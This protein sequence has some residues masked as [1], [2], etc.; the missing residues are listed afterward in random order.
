MPMRKTIFIHIGTHKTGSTSIQYFLQENAER[1]KHCGVYVARSGIDVARRRQGNHNVAWDVRRDIRYERKLGGVA[2]LLDE[3][4]DSPEKTVVISSED[5]E[6]LVRY[7]EELKEF[8]RKL[9]AIGYDRIY[10]VFFRN[11]EDYLFSLHCE[12]KKHGIVASYATLKNEV[13]NKGYILVKGD[14]Y[15]EFD[16]RRFLADWEKAVGPNLKAFDFDDVSRQGELLP[17]FLETIGASADIIQSSIHARR[18]NQNTIHADADCPC[19]S[20]KR[21]EHCHGPSPV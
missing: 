15:Y 10:L 8:D 20:G 18:L 19:G 16:R 12:L 6:Y 21:Y 7:P 1:L 13:Q 11:P 3:L 2:E 9:E 4:R 5:F 14:W 17:F